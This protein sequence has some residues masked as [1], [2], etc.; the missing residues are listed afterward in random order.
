MYSSVKTFDRTTLRHHPQRMVP[1]REYISGNIPSHNHPG[2]HENQCPVDLIC[3]ECHFQRTQRY[4]R[5]SSV[6]RPRRPQGGGQEM[7]SMRHVQRCGARRRWA[8][9]ENLRGNKCAVQRDGERSCDS[10]GSTGFVGEGYASVRTLTQP[11]I[12]PS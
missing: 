11:S 12:P 10:S 7:V 4:L 6:S 5:Y 9:H 2:S 8:S 3:L 1:S